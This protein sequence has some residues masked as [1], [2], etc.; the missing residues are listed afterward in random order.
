MGFLSM[1]NETCVIQ[2]FSD[3]QTGTGEVTRTWANKATGVQTRHHTAQREQVIDGD[4][5]VTLEDFVFYFASGV[6]IDKADRIVV[7]SDAFE[8]MAVVEHSKQHHLTVYARKTAD[9][10]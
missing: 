4:Y 1:L 9:F 2:S 7:G 10:N 5:K 8:V 3:A 6:S